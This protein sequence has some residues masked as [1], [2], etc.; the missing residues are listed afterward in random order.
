MEVD[1][2]ILK[3]QRNGIYKSIIANLVNRYIYKKL[4]NIEESI[5]VDN[6]LL[7]KQ[8]KA[9]YK[10]IITDLTSRYIDKNLRNFEGRDVSSELYHT[11]LLG[12]EG[13]I[14]V[15]NFEEIPESRRTEQMYCMV[16]KEHP[17]YFLHIPKDK[18]TYS[19]CETVLATEK[20]K[21]ILKSIPIEFLDEKLCILAFLNQNID[22]DLNSSLSSGNDESL[23]TFRKNFKRL[24]FLRPILIFVEKIIQKFHRT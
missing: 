19:M 14:S 10:S 21:Q 1:N 15:E 6:E 17:L 16:L 22:S 8:S 13:N 18:I 7:T 24:F 23:I 2:K 5:E 4:R 20:S 9:I 11:Y 12:K 3:N